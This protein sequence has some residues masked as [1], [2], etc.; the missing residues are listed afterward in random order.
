MH[1]IATRNEFLRLRSQGLSF[2]RIGRRLGVSK[3]TLIAWSR[4]SMPELQALIRDDQHRL[5]QEL[6]ASANQELAALTRK[7]TA[8][9]QELLSRAF[10]DI[11]T[12]EIEILAGE[13]RRRIDALQPPPSAAPSPQQVVTAAQNDAT[14][15][16]E[17]STQV[18]LPHASAIAPIHPSISPRPEPIRT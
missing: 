10:R 14:T 17:R 16:P 9:R 15:L 7:H 3:P 1:P 12:P 13:L 2:A 8:L 4:R 5:Q 6:S 18:P 11:P